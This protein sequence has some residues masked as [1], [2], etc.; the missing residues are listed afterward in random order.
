MQK[1]PWS[2]REWCKALPGFLTLPFI[3]LHR[4]LWLS[5]V[6]I[7]TGMKPWL[8]VKGKSKVSRKCNHCKTMSTCIKTNW[9]RVI[10]H[11]ENFHRTETRVWKGTGLEAK[12]PWFLHLISP[13]NIIY[14]ILS[15]PL[16][17]LCLSNFIFTMTEPGKP[18][19]KPLPVLQSFWLYNFQGA[20]QG[21]GIAN[22][23]H[24]GKNSSPD[25]ENG[26]WYID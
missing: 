11:V 22:A 12:R 18:T 6:I 10:N 19:A 21:G 14:V 17:P 3:T 26:S 5:S 16:S 23:S 4:Y 1:A 20:K 24:N 7:T 8:Q 13:L 25:V 15:R 9:N 2:S